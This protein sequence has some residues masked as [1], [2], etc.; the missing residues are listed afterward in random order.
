M[1]LALC[2]YYPFP[3]AHGPLKNV[4]FTWCLRVSKCDV[5]EE[6]RSCL[7]QTLP[8]E[9]CV[10]Y[11]ANST[12][13]QAQ[14]KS[15]FFL[16]L[17]WEPSGWRTKGVRRKAAL[18][19]H[20]VWSPLPWGLQEQPQCVTCLP[21]IPTWFPS[22]SK[23]DSFHFLFQKNEVLKVNYME[24][25]YGFLNSCF[26]K[27][28]KQSVFLSLKIYFFYFLKSSVL[29]MLDFWANQ[30]RTGAKVVKHENV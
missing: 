17:N 28:E 6:L 23:A 22:L 4:W 30:K 7:P 21:H 11:I 2:W 5:T 29:Q 18:L 19:P 20:G 10:V 25:L 9:G 26:L 1:N 27:E 16:I 13:I 3:I 8:G 14:R 12:L 24:R 15:D